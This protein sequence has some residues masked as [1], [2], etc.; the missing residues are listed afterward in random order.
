M[1]T[2]IQI[3][4]FG[5]DL[6]TIAI[7]LDQKEVKALY[8]NNKALKEQIKTLEKE[9]DSQKTNY[10]WASEAR[11]TARSEIAQASTL[12]TALGVQLKTNEEESYRQTELPIATRIALYIATNK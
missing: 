1:T 12:L 6:E 5:T 4:I 8:E 3:E 10:K 2:S 11:D 9:L 7:T